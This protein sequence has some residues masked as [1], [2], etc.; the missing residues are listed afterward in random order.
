MMASS[1]MNAM[2]NPTPIHIGDNTHHQDQSILPS[3]LSVMNTIVR[4]PGNPMPWYVVE[5]VG[6]IFLR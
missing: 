3:N 5:L 6:F 4:R 2:N 1:N